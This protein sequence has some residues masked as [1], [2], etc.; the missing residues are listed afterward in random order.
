MCISSRRNFRPSEEGFALVSAIVFLVLVLTLGVNM[1][2]HAM[3]E[4]AGASR[5]KKENRAFQLA[6]AGLDYAA[7]QLYN[8]GAHGLPAT[9]T[10]TDLAGGTFTVTADHYA[11][12][13]DTLLL[14]ST[15]NSQGWIAQIRA[16][17]RFLGTGGTGQNAVFDHAL[18]SDANLSLSG[19][20]DVTGH[21]HTNGNAAVK[22]NADIDG[23]LSAV[24]SVTFTG[25]PDISGD[26]TPNVARIEPPTIDLEYYRRIADNYYTGDQTLSGDIALDGVTFIDGDAHINGNFSGAGVIVVTGDVHINGNA[27]IQQPGDEFAIIT[28]GSVRINGNCSVEG[29]IYAH[30]MD[31]PGLFEGN[32]NAHI[33]GGV[34]ADVISCNGNMTIEYNSPTVDLPGSSSAPSQFDGICWQRVR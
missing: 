18:L 17:G 30:N 7:W 27:T 12:A 34:A 16:V 11:G 19:S 20:F 25:N 8:N 24:G 32:G 15:G 21:V 2:Q 6:D 28:C 10:R 1:I 29:W 3:Q 33:V 26:V 4:V 22:G 23:D 9:W 14:L 13:A 31:V 5:A